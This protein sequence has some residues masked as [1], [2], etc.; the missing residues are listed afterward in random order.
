MPCHLYLPLIQTAFKSRSNLHLPISYLQPSS[1][2]TFTCHIP[3][4]EHHVAHCLPQYLSPTGLVTSLVTSRILIWHVSSPY[5][6]PPTVDHHVRHWRHPGFCSYHYPCRSRP[7]QPEN[8]HQC[9]SEDH[10]RSEESESRLGHWV[11]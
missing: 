7:Y 2:N 10:R 6:Y 11:Q 9:S 8:S 1:I 3:S 4:N 5:A